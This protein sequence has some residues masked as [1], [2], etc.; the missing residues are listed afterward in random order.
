[1]ISAVAPGKLMFSGEYAI[2]YGQPAITMSINMY[3]CTHI[4][5]NNKPCFHF[6]SNQINF[7]ATSVLTELSTIREQVILRYQMFLKGQLSILKVFNHQGEIIQ[8]AVSYFLTHFNCHNKLGFDLEIIS[9]IPIGGGL[10]SSA[11]L[12]ISLLKSLSA[13]YDIAVSCSQYVKLGQIIEQMQHGYSSGIDIKTSLKQGYLYFHQ[14]KVVHHSAPPKLPIYLVYTGTPETNTGECV[15]YVTKNTQPQYWKKFS[16]LTQ[17]MYNALNNTCLEEIKRLLKINHR[18]LNGIGVVPLR[19]QQFIAQI[20][21][22]K[23]AGKI[24]GA[25][26]CRGEAGGAVLVLTEKK[27]ALQKLCKKYNYLLYDLNLSR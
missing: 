25:G 2:L 12:I 17:A 4:I 18:L 21:N 15:A 23:G 24:C 3:A 7:S 13:Y 6:K 20:E 8:W 14:G 22:I 16:Q 11:A 27:L 10:G 1:M 19:I 26:A 5:P 9:D